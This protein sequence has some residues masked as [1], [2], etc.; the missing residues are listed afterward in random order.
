MQTTFQQ[1]Q[2]RIIEFVGRSLQTSG[3]SGGR[4]IG[5]RGKWQ[6]ILINYC[7]LSLP[8]AHGDPLQPTNFPRGINE[9][10]DYQLPLR[11]SVTISLPKYLSRYRR[12]IAICSVRRPGPWTRTSVTRLRKRRSPESVQVRF[13]D[14]KEFVYSVEYLE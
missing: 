13:W 10:W 3:K 6:N 9:G 4:P 12:N 5:P 1:T 14:T 7:Q 2:C 8:L 11:G